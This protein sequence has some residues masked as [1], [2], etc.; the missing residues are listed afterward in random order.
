MP[1]AKAFKKS[2]GPYFTN[3]DGTLNL[4]FVKDGG[5]LEKI[6]YG[7]LYGHN[8]K[9]DSISQDKLNTSPRTQRFRELRKKLSNK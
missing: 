9:S 1:S 6:N 8:L 4:A 2:T 7:W 3:E 5:D